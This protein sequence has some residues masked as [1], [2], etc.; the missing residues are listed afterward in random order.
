MALRPAPYGRALAALVGV[1][2][3]AASCSRV[4]VRATT[5]ASADRRPVAKLAVVLFEN[6]TTNEGAA[7]AITAALVNEL[8]R[9]GRFEVI[10]IAKAAAGRT[11]RWTAAKIGAEAKA[12]A[13]LVGLVTAFEYTRNAQRGSASMSPTIG[14]DLRVVAAPAGD[15]LWAAGLDAK[16]LQLWSAEG[17]PLEQLAQEVAERVA[18]ELEPLGASD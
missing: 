9:R 10:E 3:A 14:L 17:M 12:D 18:D 1:C 7:Q 16:L 2:C 6:L 4:Q 11:E 15:V 8:R 5:L 13:V